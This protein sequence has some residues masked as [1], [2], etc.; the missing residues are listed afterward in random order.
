VAPPGATRLAK[1]PALPSGSPTMTVASTAQAQAVGYWRVAGAPQAL[2][3]WEKAHI[4]RS[5]SAQDVIL[6]PPSWNTVYSLPPVPGV[7]S[8]REMNVQVYDVGGGTT[9]IMADAMSDWEPPRPAGEVIPA[10]VHAVTVAPGIG[11]GFS[12]KP[13]TVTS[14]AAVKKLAALVN[15]LPVSTLPDDIPCPG[16]AGITLTFYDSRAATGKP[17]AVATGPV[18]CGTVELTLNG[19][20][21][22]DLEPVDG[23]AYQSA[24]LTTA[25]VRADLG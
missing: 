19:K 22:P 3:A 18:G 4:S 13:V 20:K 14:A 5:F 1:R 6:G 9:V 11:P 25:G 2:L 10:G 8:K 23:S 21:Q 16:Q 7:L 17:V 15:G 12:F 24:V